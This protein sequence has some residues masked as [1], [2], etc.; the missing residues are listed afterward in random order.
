MQSIPSIKQLKCPKS[1]LVKLTHRFH[2]RDPN[3]IQRKGIL[4]A[5]WSVLSDWEIFWNKRSSPRT[6]RRH[7]GAILT[8]SGKGKMRPVRQI[9]KPIFVQRK[10]VGFRHPNPANCFSKQK[11]SGRKMQ[12]QSCYNYH[13]EQEVNLGTKSI[14]APEDGRKLSDPLEPEQHSIRH[15]PTIDR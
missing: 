4:N 14:Q 1:I 12:Q 5:G 15:C 7:I 13:F 3:G 10:L 11:F 9:W 2:P 6:G 8:I